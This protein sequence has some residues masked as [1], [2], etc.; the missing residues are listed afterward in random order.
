MERHL[1]DLFHNELVRHGLAAKGGCS[2]DGAFVEAPTQHNSRDENAQIKRGVIPE[3]FTSIR[4]WVAIKIRMH[5]GR[6][7]MRKSIL[8]IKITCLP[9]PIQ[10]TILDYEVTDAAV[11]DSIPCLEVVP[12]EPLYTGQEIYLDSACVGSERNPIFDDL[13]ERGFNPQICEKGVRNPPLTPLQ[14]FC[15]NI[16]S[17]VRCRIEHIFGAQKKTNG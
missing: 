4:M 7:R 13:K 3:R 14:K 15:N 5:V 8:V 10:I 12:P 1:F 2:M 11:H 9:I 6:K 17:R 16:K